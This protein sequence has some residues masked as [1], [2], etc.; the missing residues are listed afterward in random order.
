VG[1]G[2]SVTGGVPNMQARPRGVILFAL[3]CFACA[4]LMVFATIFATGMQSSRILMLF[5]A[6]LS[7][8]V[9]YGLWTLKYRAYLLTVILLVAGLI[10]RGMSLFG[11]MTPGGVVVNLL[12]IIMLIAAIR[13][14]WK[15]SVRGTFG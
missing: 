11:N 9:G 1:K 12:A 5:S 6:A 13:Y 4:G 10:Q 14:F 3:L 8:G 2:L 15:P 7:G